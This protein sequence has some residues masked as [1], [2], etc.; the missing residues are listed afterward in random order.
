VGELGAEL[1]T[2]TYLDRSGK[3]KRVR[4]WAMTVASGT[5]GA[6]NEVDRAEWVPVAEA[7]R[8]LSYAHDK[9]VLDALLSVLGSDALG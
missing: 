3:Q 1:P 5:P 4:Y 2:I 9:S 6:A 7:A 8:R